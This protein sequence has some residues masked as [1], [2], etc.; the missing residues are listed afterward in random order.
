L[1]LSAWAPG[2]AAQWLLAPVARSLCWFVASVESPD[3]F[4][5]TAA[6]FMGD[7]PQL[8]FEM[9]YGVPRSA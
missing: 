8:D 6:Q 3:R 5:H 1:D 9:T 7:G 4:A 2:L